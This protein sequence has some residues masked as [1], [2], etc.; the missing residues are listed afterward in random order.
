MAQKKRAFVVVQTSWYNEAIGPIT[1]GRD[2]QSTGNAHTIVGT[3]DDITD[4]RGVWLQD[5]PTLYRKQS[6]DRLSPSTAF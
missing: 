1:K 2:S 3:L 4:H 6:D 5:V